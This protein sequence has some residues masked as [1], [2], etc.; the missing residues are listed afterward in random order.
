MKNKLMMVF[1]A[2]LLSVC[3]TGCKGSEE[4]NT[5]AR[6]GSASVIPNANS[7]YYV[8]EEPVNN[9]IVTDRNG[10]IGDD[11]TPRDNKNGSMGKAV[12]NIGDTLDNAAD[13]I[14][15]TASNITSNAGNV[16]S[17]AAWKAPSGTLSTMFQAGALIEL[18]GDVDTAFE[19]Y[20][21]TY[22]IHGLPPLK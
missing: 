11:D 18:S 15:N 13:N 10:I 19:I 9:G 4:N 1:A 22:N 2:A 6:D 14:G 20:Y 12:E 7:G 8:S 16:V 17:N 3:L 5:A 21:E